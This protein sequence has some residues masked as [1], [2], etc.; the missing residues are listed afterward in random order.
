MDQFIDKWQP[1]RRCCYMTQHNNNPS[2]PSVE[3]QQT[4]TPGLSNFSLSVVDSSHHRI[5][6]YQSVDKDHEIALSGIGQQADHD[7]LSFDHIID[8]ALIIALMI[9]ND[10]ADDEKEEN[11]QMRVEQF[12]EDNASSEI[13]Q[14]GF[15]NPYE[16]S[17]SYWIYPPVSNETLFA[18]AANHPEFYYYPEVFLWM[19]YVLM[20]RSLK[21][22]KSREKLKC[23]HPECVKTLNLKSFYEEPRAIRV[24]DLHENFYL[25][26]YRYECSTAGHS[27]TSGVDPAVIKQLPLRYQLEFPA[28]LTK[29]SGIS[30]NL[31][32]L[33]RFGA[34]SSLG[35]SKL[36]KILN[37]FHHLRH[38]ENELRYLDTLTNFLKI[39]EQLPGFTN[40]EGIKKVEFSPFED[41]EKYSGSVPSAGYLTYVYCSMIQDP[42]PLM[43]QLLSLLDGGFLKA[44]HS[45]KITDHMGKLNKVHVNH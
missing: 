32:K 8:E 24:A 21:D 5:E 16:K 39:Q 33:I 26:T 23:S 3:I 2:S 31:G 45:F 30:K 19:P 27:A 34:Q 35:Q 42:R 9:S 4:A 17:K 1:A 12:E 28:H 44:D 37:E 7:R 14:N 38:D 18:K 36:S 15:L 41:K 29:R 10:A 6:N 43:D 40:V 22:P 20:D 25:M 11:L 13:T